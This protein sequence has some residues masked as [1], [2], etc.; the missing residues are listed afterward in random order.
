MF[1]GSSLYHVKASRRAEYSLKFGPEFGLR[2]PMGKARYVASP[3]LVKSCW[4]E[5]VRSTENNYFYS[6][7]EPRN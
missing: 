5:V 1:T 4:K 2:R 3:K 6:T 7:T